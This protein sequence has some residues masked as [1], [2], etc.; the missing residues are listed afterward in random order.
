MQPEL[1]LWRRVL[2]VVHNVP[3]NRGSLAETLIPP[4][5][6]TPSN[7]RAHQAVNLLEVQAFKLSRRTRPAFGRNPNSFS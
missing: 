4:K 7:S 2:H 3:R 6:E 1:P 5:H